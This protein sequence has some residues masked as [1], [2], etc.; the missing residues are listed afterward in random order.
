[1]ITLELPEPILSRNVMDKL[2]W[3]R[4]YRMR[5]TWQWLVKAAVLEAHVKVVTV[6]HGYLTIERISPR[7]LDPD[8]FCGGCKLL[9]DAL[10]SEGF[11]VD[12]DA[13]HLTTTYIQSI[14][15]PAR[16][17]VRIGE[18]ARVPG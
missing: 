5:G 8:N 11:F 7:K 4:R 2:H 1:M 13:T 12:D 15:K 9:Q 17:V 10:V 6:P 16:T 18:A 14:G 3:A